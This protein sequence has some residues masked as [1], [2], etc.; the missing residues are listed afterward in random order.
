LRLGDL[1]KVVDVARYV[2]EIDVAIM[3]AE[4]AEEAPGRSGCRGLFSQGGL[5]H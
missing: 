3:A 5:D 4:P 2:V 1:H